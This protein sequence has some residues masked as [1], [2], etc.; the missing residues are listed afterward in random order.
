MHEKAITNVKDSNLFYD[1]FLADW[2]VNKMMATVNLDIYD[3]IATGFDRI[4]YISHIVLK[5]QIVMRIMA[6]NSDK[7]IK[8]NTMTS[9]KTW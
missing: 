8:R 4:L 5:L 9:Y 6:K 7:T 1:P 2:T 3:E